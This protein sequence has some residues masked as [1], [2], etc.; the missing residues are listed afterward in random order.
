MSGRRRISDVHAVEVPSFA[1]VAER[2]LDDVHS[3]LVYFTRDRGLA[4][5][6]TAETFE[7]A[8]RQWRRFDPRRGSARTWLC[9]LARTTALDHFRAEQ[10][11][12]RREHTY[13]I[14]QQP[15][16]DGLFGGLSPALEK[17]LGELSAGE[18]EVVAL[19]VLLDLDG[20]TAAK[21]LGISVSNCNTR[22]SRALKKLEERM[23]ADVAA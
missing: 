4:E 12:R 23:S 6:L 17:A 14:E 16:E 10:R 3:Y 8:L 13:A 1:S 19:R 5:D 21:V 15:V 18:R 22:L 9:Q 20:E 11:R 7:R 2:H